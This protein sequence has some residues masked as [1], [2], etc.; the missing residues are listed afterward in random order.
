[1]DSNTIIKYGDEQIS[2]FSDERADYISLTDMARAFKGSKSIEMWLRNQGTVS[3][4]IAW[5]KLNNPDFRT[6]DFGGTKKQPGRQHF[7][8]SVKQ[9]IELTG[10]I[11]IFATARGATAGTYAH[12]DIAFKFASWLSPEFELFLIQEFQKLKK[13]EEQ[14]NSYELLSHEQILYLVR[15]KEVFKYVAH[16]EIVEEAHKEVFASKSNAKN[17]FAEF[18]VWRNKILDIAPEKINERIKQ[19]CLEN[20]IAMQRGL[21]KRDKI[22]FLDSY[23]AVRNAVWDFL[24]IKGEANALNLANLVGDMIRTEEGEVFRRNE[25]TLFETKQNLGEFTDFKENIHKLPEVKTARQ[26]LALKEASKN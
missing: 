1:M 12:K 7:N 22:L 8:L 2:L 10:G 3:F 14:K 11:G 21:S 17:P 16:Q 26:L 19:Y 25:D 24:K 4:L 15:L 18:N 6:P 5:E 13:I 23:D 20:K 9:W